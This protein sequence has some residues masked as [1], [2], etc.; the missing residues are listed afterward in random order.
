MQTKGVVGLG[1]LLRITLIG[2]LAG[3]LGTGMGGI[4]VFIFRRPTRR[5]LSGIV[6]LSS[7]L[8]LAIISFEMLPEAFLLT[9]VLIAIL[10]LI[11]GAFVSS[12]LDTFFEG[13]G[14]GELKTGILLGIAIALHNFP[15]GLA[16]GSGF[17]AKEKLGIGLA[18]IIALHNIPEGVA[19][20]TPMRIGGYSPL[21]AFAMTLL[22]GAPM[23]LGACIGSLIG[24]LG[25]NLIG[26]CLSFA[27]GTMLYITLGELLPKGK[28][29]DQGRISTFYAI[30]GVV[31]GIIISKTF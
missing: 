6:G 1:E 18:I 7:G 30:L 15:E 23:G 29:L 19:M 2:L 8:M 17:I 25:S 3:V 10:G 14:K 20:A 11:L 24:N 21:K 26:F 4:T 16:I 27:A 31:V 22:A 12:S 9:N 5:F 28:A 13:T